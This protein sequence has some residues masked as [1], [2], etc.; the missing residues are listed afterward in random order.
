MV[1]PLPVATQVTDLGTRLQMRRDGSQTPLLK[2]R[3]PEGVRRAGR[4]ARL[5]LCFGRR[6]H[7]LA[8]S[9]L[10]SSLYG[11]ALGPVPL[12]DLQRLRSAA[13]QALL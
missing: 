1:A 11:A 10:T 2:V 9:A 8:S 12:R 7:L 13:M 5:P 6:G 4:V 3:L